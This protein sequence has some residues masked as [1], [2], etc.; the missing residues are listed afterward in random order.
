VG[1]GHLGAGHANH[2]D[3][4]LLDR[5]ASLRRERDA[6]RVTQ[7]VFMMPGGSLGIMRRGTGGRWLPARPTNDRHQEILRTGSLEALSHGELA[8]SIG[9]EA[10]GGAH[11]FPGQDTVR[12]LVLRVDFLHD[13]SGTQTTGDGKFDLTTGGADPPPVDAPPLP[14]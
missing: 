8:R 6:G 7:D 10:I 2:V 9:P 3:Q 11:S 4:A 13:R 12:I 14:P 1:L 5:V